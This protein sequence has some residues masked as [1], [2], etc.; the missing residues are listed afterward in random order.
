MDD[1]TTNAVNDLTHMAIVYQLHG[2]TEKA[3]EVMQL[4]ERMKVPKTGELVEIADY[5]DREQKQA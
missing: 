1:N 2:M 4:V 3:A 5:Q